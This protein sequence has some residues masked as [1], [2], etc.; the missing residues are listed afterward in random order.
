MGKYDPPDMHVA[1][2]KD[3][4]KAADDSDDLM[5]IAFE[6]SGHEAKDMTRR[7]RWISRQFAGILIEMREELEGYK[8]EHY[9][10]QIHGD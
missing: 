4:V 6:E 9:N 2:L 1:R 8:A 5:E 7:Y 3:Y 10:R